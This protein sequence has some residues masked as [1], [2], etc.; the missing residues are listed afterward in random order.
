MLKKSGLP[1]IVIDENSQ[2]GATF[3][4]RIRNAFESTFQLGY[5]QLIMVGNDTVGLHQSE[6]ARANNLLKT[7]SGVIGETTDGGSYLIGFQKAFFDTISERF[8]EISWKTNTVF[9]ELEALIQPDS[10][11]QFPVKYDL[12]TAADLNALLTRESDHSIRKS[13]LTLLANLTDW[14]SFPVKR[15]DADVSWLIANSLKA[16]PINS[17][18]LSK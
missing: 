16:P 4:E 10:R 17:V 14:L 7:Q 9:S 1:I 5:D 12:D 2:V 6:I 15:K 11:L 3:G 8:Q 13:V 18:P